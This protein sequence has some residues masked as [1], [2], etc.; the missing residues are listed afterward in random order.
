VLY[1]ISTASQPAWA[2]WKV[3]VTGEREP[4]PIVQREFNSFDGRLSPDGQ[5][6]AYT[7]FD[8]GAQEVYVQ[9]V[10][11]GDKRQISHGGG[12]HA[13]WTQN[14]RELVYWAIPGGVASVGLDTAGSQLRIGDAATLVATRI[15]ALFDSRSHY[16][17]TRDGQR[18][19]LRQPLGA[20][21]PAVTVMVNWREKLKK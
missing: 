3:A 5:W 6:L 11:G 16:D 12:V 14:G 10:S 21:H 20:Q 17:V 4:T 9:R 2:I 15:L 8:T 7:G 1:S 18:F 13:R 19:L